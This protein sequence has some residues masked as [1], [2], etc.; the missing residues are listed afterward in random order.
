MFLIDSLYSIGHSNGKLVLLLKYSSIAQSHTIIKE[1]YIC[2]YFYIVY[3]I[4]WESNMLCEF[5]NL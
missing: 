3:A 5:R 2:S 1:I 4:K